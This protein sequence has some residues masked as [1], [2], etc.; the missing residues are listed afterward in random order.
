MLQN[1]SSL[2]CES[3]GL[4][5]VGSVGTG[6]TCHCSLHRHSAVTAGWTPSRCETRA[7]CVEGTTARAAPATALSRP[8]G[9]EVGASLGVDGRAPASLQET[10]AAQSLGSE[11]RTLLAGLGLCPPPRQPPH[12][13]RSLMRPPRGGSGVLGMTAHS[14]CDA[15]KTRILGGLWEAGL[16]PPTQGIPSEGMLYLGTPWL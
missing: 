9:P 15:D 12:P 7:R 3:Q 2:S 14:S 4:R 13:A 6:V 16:A 1:A 11:P 10:P 5:A 8:E